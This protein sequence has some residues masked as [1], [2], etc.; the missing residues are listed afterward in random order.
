MA[1][2]AEFAHTQHQG[3]K[4][5]ASDTTADQAFYGHF[6]DVNMSGADTL[7]AD[8]IH[9]GLYVDVDS[10]ATGGDTTNE[11]RV[12]GVY[13][14]V[15]ATQDS[16]LIYG[17]YSLGRSQHSIG[18]VSNL[19]GAQNYG[20]GNNSAGK[21][22][23]V[24]GAYNFGRS[25][26]SGTGEIDNL[27]GAFNIAQ[28]YQTSTDTGTIY[29]GSHN[30][31]QY[32]GTH[33]VDAGQ[34]RGV[35]AEVQIDANSNSWALTSAYMFRA[36]FDNND[37]INRTTN[38]YLFYGNYSG[39]L[40][41]NAWGV[42]IPADVKN[43][44]AGNVGIGITT[45][46]YEL[47]VSNGG[48]EGIEFGPAYTT[49]A[50]LIQHYNRSGAAYLRADNIASQHRFLIGANLA[51]DIQA[52]RLEISDDGGTGFTHSRVITNSATAARGSGHF[53]HNTDS[54]TEWYMGRPYVTG[55]AWQVSRRATATHGDS[56]ADTQ[57]ALLTVNNSGDVT[58]NGSNL[59]FY[60][61]ST[62]HDQQI[63]FG[64]TD[65]T[66]AGSIRYNHAND[67]FEF[68]GR[69]DGFILARFDS[70]GDLSTFYNLDV[71]GTID[72]GGDISTPTDVNCQ[73]LIA[74]GT[75]QATG[76]V[77]GNSFYVG[78]TNIVD[79]SRNL[80]NIGT[81]N[82]GAITSTGLAATGDI[83]TT[84]EL[85]VGT[86]ISAE[87][88]HFRLRSDFNAGVKQHSRCGASIWF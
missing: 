16:D 8:R 53:M 73:D 15:R 82:S 40:P 66:A 57:Y 47:V 29:T 17:S 44:F 37:T 51:A 19:Y 33:S 6:L 42:Y 70:A 58:I 21:T 56:T 79:A 88:R 46:A 62:T 38:G 54:D 75:V 4:I 80:V 7:T 55:D 1:G 13:S 84:T 20:F 69:G 32:T 72:A 26:V 22:T 50:N 67:N 48:A 74:T 11:H 61:N 78:I 63:Y 34:A 24:Y 35:W 65:N 2:N 81:I 5:T 64:D 9:A 68:N 52:G 30:I 14:D 71:D 23:N 27:Y 36:E 85:G 18:T 39:I 87:L 76:L 83:T 28:S 31:V 77:A 43:Y 12:Y 3:F 10:T 60:E 86:T 49:G 41:T 25:S 59:Y 45:G